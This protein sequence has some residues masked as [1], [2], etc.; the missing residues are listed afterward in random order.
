PKSFQQGRPAE[1]QSPFRIRE[2]CGRGRARDARGREPDLVPGVVALPRRC[3]ARQSA[4][5]D[6]APIEANLVSEAQAGVVPTPS[7]ARVAERNSTA[8]VMLDGLPTL[9][10]EEQERANGEAEHHD[11]PDER[12]EPRLFRR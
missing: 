5:L 3:G 4:P 9:P 8:S 11:D 7:P 12:R 10:G 6:V 1:N 2:W